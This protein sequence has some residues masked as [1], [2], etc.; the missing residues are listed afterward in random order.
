MVD[1]MPRKQD[2]DF[3]ADMTYS[4]R[5][6]IASS[7]SSDWCTSV[8]AD[9]KA[10]SDKVWSETLGPKTKFRSASAD[11]EKAWRMCFETCGK[12]TKSELRIEDHYVCFYFRRTDG[13]IC[14]RLSVTSFNRSSFRKFLFSNPFA[15]PFLL[16]VIN[17]RTLVDIPPP[18]FLPL[19][20]NFPFFFSPLSFFFALMLRCR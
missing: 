20:Y 1:A 6:R 2:L 16:V 10:V 17:A 7:A 13:A 14:S 5:Q 3:Q 18:P 19:T 4:E 11:T 15:L 12:G 8:K 9:I